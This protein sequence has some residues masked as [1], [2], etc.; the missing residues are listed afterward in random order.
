M[1]LVAISLFAMLGIV[2]AACGNENVD[3]AEE[4]SVAETEQSL[5]GREY[6]T[7]YYSDASKTVEV[8]YR[9][10][11]CYGGPPTT[12]GQVTIHRTTVWGETCEPITTS[13]GGGGCC[14]SSGQCP[15][16]CS[17]CVNC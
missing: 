10:Y 16:E 5:P 14:Y 3:E 6:E 4:G 13:G 11:T 17:Y 15:A 12:T 2:V 8:G 9:I 7:T 1:K